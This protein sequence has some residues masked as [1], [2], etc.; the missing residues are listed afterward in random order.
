MVGIIKREW[1]SDRVRL[2]LSNDSDDRTLSK[3]ILYRQLIQSKFDLLDA[4]EE[5]MY[6][7]ISE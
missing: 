4:V 1:L 3:E 6:N 7:Q 5:Q 2:T